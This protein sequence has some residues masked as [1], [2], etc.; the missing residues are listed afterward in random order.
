MYMKNAQNI[1]LNNFRYNT[2]CP[3][4][5]KISQEENISLKKL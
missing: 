3:L 4:T 5:N 1:I 2:K